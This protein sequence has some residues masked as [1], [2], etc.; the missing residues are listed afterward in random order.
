MTVSQILE[1]I[2][3]KLGALK[4]EHIDGTIFEGEKEENIRKQLKSY[5][6]RDDGAETVYDGVNGREIQSRILI[7]NI[8]YM[9]LKYLVSN[10]LHSRS[11]GPMQLLTRQPTE[12]RAKE[13]GLKLGE[14]E[15]D[16]LI[17]HGAS[18]L[19]KERFDSD[20]TDLPICTSCGLIALYNKFRN[21]AVC[22]A[23]KDSKIKFVEMSYA[24]KLLL[25]ELRS[26]GIHPRIVLKPKK[27]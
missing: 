7:G 5:G 18:L 6:Y 12:G 20:K 8:Y 16:V 21:E 11:R 3:G 25:D 23:C 4:G 9:K 10:K 2:A 19:L 27:G 17:A 14:M 13:G 1:I 24:F 15:K 22:S 26:L